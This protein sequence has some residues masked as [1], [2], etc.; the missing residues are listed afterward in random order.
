[1]KASYLPLGAFSMCDWTTHDI[2]SNWQ[3]HRSLLGNAAKEDHCTKE[4]NL[5]EM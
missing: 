2:L 3:T 4:A 1:M 5:S